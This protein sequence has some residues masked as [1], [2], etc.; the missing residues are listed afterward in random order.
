MMIETIIETILAWTLSGIGAA[1][2]LAAL[3][4][5]ITGQV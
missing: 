2:L 5:L 1:T 3:W 4:L